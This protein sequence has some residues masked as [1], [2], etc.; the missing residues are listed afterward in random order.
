[1]TVLDAL[2]SLAL[3]SRLEAA[4]HL[5]FLL[6][7]LESDPRL[8]IKLTCLRY[9]RLRSLCL[10]LR[11]TPPSSPDACGN[12]RQR[13]GRMLSCAS[14]HWPGWLLPESPYGL[15]R[16]SVLLLLVRVSS[17]HAMEPAEAQG[18]D[19]LVSACEARR[20]RTPSPLSPS[21]LIVFSRFFPLISCQAE[22]AP[23]R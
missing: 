13:L 18:W 22:L 14:N 8:A 23:Q 1:V 7:R 3:R 5:D 21:T 19:E 17:L 10:P 16:R 4:S 15:V 6:E 20:R 11:L 2:T 12:L 9:H